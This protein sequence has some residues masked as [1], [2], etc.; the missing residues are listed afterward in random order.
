MAAWTLSTLVRSRLNC[1]GMMELAE[2]LRRS[3]GSGRGFGQTGARAGGNGRNHDVCRRPDRRPWN[4][5]LGIST[6]EAREIKKLS[7]RDGQP[8]SNSIIRRV[9]ATGRKMNGRD[10]L[11]EFYLQAAL[12]RTFSDCGPPCAAG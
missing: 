5:D 9:V 8:A 4:L 2:E 1:S 3:S 6:E 10:G 7:V 11:I 12:K